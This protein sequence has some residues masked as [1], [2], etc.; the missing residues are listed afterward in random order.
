MANAAAS[1]VAEQ[2][3]LHNSSVLHP[4]TV[5]FPP[6]LAVAQALGE[7][8]PSCSRRSSPAT[9]SASASASSSAART[10]PSSTPPAPPERSPPRRRWAT[11]SASTPIAWRTPSARRARRPPA[12]GNSCATAA[13]SKQL[14]TAHAASAGLERGLPRRR[15][16]H[17]RQA[18]LRRQAG[19]GRGPLA[20]RR[21]GAPGRPPRH[22]LGLARDLVQVPRL[23]PAHAS[24]RRCLA[25]GDAGERT[26]RRRHR[27]G[28]RAGP[29]G[30][31]ST[32]SARS[33][34]RRPCTSRS[35]RW[36]PC[37]A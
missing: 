20:R 24:R 6:A 13:D 8:A 9:R 16:I 18:H 28:H 26:S 37:S 14:H 1:H 19:N 32:C 25:A 11:C 30:R 12:S 36:E 5:V 22:A 34:I 33:S 4:A 15:R 21:S 7:A 23:V 3:D 29:P 27:G 35:S 10:T 2:D 17:R 31:G